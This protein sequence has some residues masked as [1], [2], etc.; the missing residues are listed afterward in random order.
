[1]TAS[2]PLKVKVNH[3]PIIDPRGSQGEPLSAAE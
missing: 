1:M 3:Y 2:A